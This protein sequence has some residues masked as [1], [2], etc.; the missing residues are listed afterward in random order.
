MYLYRFSTQTP[1][2]IR[3]KTTEQLTEALSNLKSLFKFMGI[4]TAVILVIYGLVFFWVS[5]DSSFY[6]VSRWIVFSFCIPLPS[7]GVVYFV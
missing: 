1:S 7:L 3:S 4:Y 2:S 5:D 6:R